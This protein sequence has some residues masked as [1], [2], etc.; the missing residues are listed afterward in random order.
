MVHPGHYRR[1]CHKQY[2]LSGLSHIFSAARAFK[3][4]CRES[5]V[6]SSCVQLQRKELHA[7]YAL[8]HVLYHRLLFRIVYIGT[9][10]SVWGFLPVGNGDYCINRADKTACDNRCHHRIARRSSIGKHSR[11]DT[12]HDVSG[13]LMHGSYNILNQYK[14]KRD[15]ERYLVFLWRREWDLR[16]LRCNPPSCA[17]SFSLLGPSAIQ[18]ATGTFHF[19]PMPFRVRIPRFLNY[20]KKQKALVKRAFCFWR[21][22]WDSN[23]RS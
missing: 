4:E 13:K 23:P 18:G 21:R 10:P 16:G 8:L 2:R 3:G 7:K 14:E 15:T 6:N 12:A 11:M 9:G 1:Y 5:P 17:G 22:E 20:T 19:T